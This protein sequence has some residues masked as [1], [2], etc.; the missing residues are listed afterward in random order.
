MRIQGLLFLFLLLSQIRAL[1]TEDL[2]LWD[3]GI[4]LGFVRFEDYPASYEERDFFLPFP[5]FQYRGEMLRADDREGA[6]AYLYKTSQGSL[7]LGGGLIPGLDSDDNE[8][9]RG[10]DDLLWN[11]YMGPQFVVRPL[12]EIE[13]KV[14][15]F[16]SLLSNLQTTK[17][18]G[19]LSEAQALWH[20]DRY[21]EKTEAFLRAE[22]VQGR[23][24]LN[25]KA[26][27]QKFLAPYYEVGVIDST[28]ARPTYEAQGGILSW[29]FSYF[30]SVEV[31][32]WKFYGGF[33]ETHYD[34]SSNKQSPLHQRERNLGVFAG[35][36]YTLGE[37]EKRSVP[38]EE[39]KGFLD[40]YGRNPL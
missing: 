32:K 1:A 39:T 12:W 30:Q 4:G 15:I 11:I 34:I 9:R 5:A 18:G 25:V 10:M 35:L 22:R 26:A 24:G 36:T 14:G 16:Q 6:R 40:R 31:R 2:P 27:D 37:S 20:V 3:Y 17:I 33:A 8:A 29:S 38:L 19:W 13:F 7:E 28:A 23:F 21:L